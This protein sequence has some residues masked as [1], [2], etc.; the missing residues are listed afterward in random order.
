M[1]NMLKWFFPLKQKTNSGK[2]LITEQKMN[3]R[4]L[5]IVETE[6]QTMVNC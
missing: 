6:K 2:Y 5:L 3:N 4:K 1:R